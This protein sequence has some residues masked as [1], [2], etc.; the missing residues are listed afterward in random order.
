MV[1]EDEIAPQDFL[2]K[3]IKGENV[4]L[5]IYKLIMTDKINTEI[6][7]DPIRTYGIS[8][9]S[10]DSTQDVKDISI[11][12]EYV[13]SL[14]EKYNRLELSPLHLRDVIFDIL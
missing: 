7:E 2:K 12:K 3:I 5:N 13:I 11:N 9:E 8:V 14:V 1:N 6:S 10:E 4:I